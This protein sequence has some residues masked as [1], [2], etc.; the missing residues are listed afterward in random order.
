MSQIDISYDEMKKEILEELSKHQFL[1]LATSK[2]NYVRAGNMR[3]IYDDLTLYCYTGNKSRKY[4]QIQS[5][6]KIAVVVSKIQIEGKAKLLKHP[7]DE[8]RFLEIYK[9]THTDAYERHLTRY[10]KGSKDMRVI[11]ITPERLTTF[12]APS[13][14]ERPYLD[15]MI[16]SEKKAYRIDAIDA[17]KSTVYP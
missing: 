1:V 5:N 8:P 12:N 17:S 3:Y 15:I 16:C 6:P 2:D 14:P 7:L 13:L 11:Q 10:F 4:T 9:K